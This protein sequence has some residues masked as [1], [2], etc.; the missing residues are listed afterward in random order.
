M[1]CDG[2]RYDGRCEK[3]GRYAIYSAPI[4]LHDGPIAHACWPHLGQLVK[5]YIRGP[6]NRLVVEQI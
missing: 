6:R 4:G 2:Q 1:T 5:A 3:R